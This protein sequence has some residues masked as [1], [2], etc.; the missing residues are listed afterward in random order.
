MNSV[1]V[2]TKPKPRNS[3]I[4]LLR[5]IAMLMII[6]HHI[7]I[8]SGF[9]FP[10][11]TVTINQLW[12]QWI[13]LG[14]KIGVNIFVFITGYFSITS[15]KFKINKIVN[16][17]L[18]VFTYS[19]VIFLIFACF[20]NE[21]LQLEAILKGFFPIT[22]S[23]W[24]FA[25]SYFVL[26]LLTPFLNQYLNSITKKE[27]QRLLLLFMV[28]WCIIPTFL[29]NDWQGNDLLWFVFLYACAG[30]LRLHFNLETFK[31]S[32][33]FIWCF[34]LTICTYLSAII[35]DFLG[36]KISVLAKGATIFYDMQR[37]PV[38]LISI[39][40][41]LGFSQINIGNISSINFT[42][43]ATF[44]IYLIHDNGFIRPLL[45]ETLFQNTAHQTSLLLIPY[46]FAEIF[47][48]FL[49]CGAIELFRI[50]CIEK[51]YTKSVGRF[52][53]CI[54]TI[55]RRILSSKVLQKL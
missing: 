14:G 27:Y 50:H 20:G 2:I 16:L 3:N 10:T 40:L 44:G 39:T 36:T 37:L 31:R 29:F 1:S 35:L 9:S 26:Y 30:Y 41:F 28:L 11:E 45:W 38:F 25:S 8:H 23:T 32:T 13:Q 6:A 24:W 7:A 55:V 54:E 21:P 12:V 19:C 34:A 53:T 52:S 49:M 5:I 22:F 17:W 33:Y 48:V 4:E 42:S 47:I 15:G 51:L 18:Q 43:S 46:T